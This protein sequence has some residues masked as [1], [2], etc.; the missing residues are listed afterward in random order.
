MTVAT[1]RRS[2]LSVIG[3]WPMLTLALEAVRN[4]YKAQALTGTP[5]RVPDSSPHTVV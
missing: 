3:V 4:M 2:M 5:S 1:V